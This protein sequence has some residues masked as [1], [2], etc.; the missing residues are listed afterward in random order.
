[1]KKGLRVLVCFHASPH[2]LGGVLVRVLRRKVLQGLLVVT[3]VDVVAVDLED[4]LS[5][6]KPRPRRLP[7]CKCWNRSRGR[8]SQGGLRH[9]GDV[10][11]PTSGESQVKV[12]HLVSLRKVNNYSVQCHNTP[13]GSPINTFLSALKIPVLA[14]AIITQLWGHLTPCVD[15]TLGDWFRNWFSREATSDTRPWE[16]EERG[17]DWGQEE[18]GE[19]PGLKKR[20]VKAWDCIPWMCL[21]A[22]S[23][24]AVLVC[25][26]ACSCLVYTF[27]FIFH[28]T[29]HDSHLFLLR[30]GGENIWLRGHSGRN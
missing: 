10:K 6:L 8:R 18:A 1:M 21:A 5:G 30:V 12:L 13:P 17:E 9:N 7:T 15:I 16:R 3:V 29:C 19:S 14:S 26:L 24:P 11:Q 22:A 20:K 23:L 25:V 4:D 28:C 2:R 27:G